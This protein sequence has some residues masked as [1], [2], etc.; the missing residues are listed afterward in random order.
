MRQ[1]HGARPPLAVLRR[2]GAAR[3]GPEALQ[4]PLRVPARARLPALALPARLGRA[5]VLHESARIVALRVLRRHHGA[6]PRLEQHRAWREGVRA[7][8]SAPR[9]T[10]LT[11]IVALAVVVLGVIVV[12]LDDRMRVGRPLAQ[13]HT[14]GGKGQPSLA[15]PLHA[16]G[17]GRNARPQPPWPCAPAAAG[18][19]R[20]RAAGSSPPARGGWRSA[21]RSGP[22]PPRG[23]AQTG[24]AQPSPPRARARASGGWWVRE[25]RRRRDRGSRYVRA[26][27]TLSNSLAVGRPDGSFTRQRWR[28]SLKAPE[29]RSGALRVGGSRL[30]IRKIACRT[31]VSAGGTLRI[32]G[33]SRMGVGAGGSAHPHRVNGGQGWLPLRQFDRCDAEGPNVRLSRRQG[34]RASVRADSCRA[35]RRGR[36]RHARR[37]PCCRRTSSG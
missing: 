1:L 17:K 30:G 14:A 19:R 37:A 28:K 2:G 7:R 18:G 11:C 9:G 8:H 35:L 21:L 16:T 25:G 23:C 15:S 3:L 33:S 12:K 36:P 20:Q 32:W 24:A 10:L 13:A 5:K 22:A 6:A 29:N 34:R 31:P 27:R 26:C 4:G